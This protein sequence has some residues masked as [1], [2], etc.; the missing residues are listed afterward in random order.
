M[1]LFLFQEA[2]QILNI[3]DVKDRESVVKNYEHLFGVNDKSKGGSFYLQSKVRQ[4]IGIIE[5]KTNTFNELPASIFD[6]I[7]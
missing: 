5:E 4:V 6:K 3:S 7:N 1:Y 2:K